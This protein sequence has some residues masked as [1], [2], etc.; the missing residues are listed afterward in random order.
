LTERRMITPEKKEGPMTKLSKQ[1]R[2][3]KMKIG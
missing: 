1:G 3:R 2:W